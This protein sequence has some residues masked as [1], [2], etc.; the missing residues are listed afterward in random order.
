[1][2][3]KLTVELRAKPEKTQELYQTLQAL[4]PSIRKEKGCRGCRVWRDVEDE[5]IFF[6]AV[7]WDTRSSLEQSI[8]SGSGGAFLGAVD[9]LAET[10]RVRLGR[11]FAWE[12]ID[13]P[14]ANEKENIAPHGGA[15]VRAGLPERRHKQDH[16]HSRTAKERDHEK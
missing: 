15:A 2:T 6:L 12:G 5:G 9:L 16:H 7:D 10:A 3:M 4:L 13:A 1:M 11:G 8:R 14:E